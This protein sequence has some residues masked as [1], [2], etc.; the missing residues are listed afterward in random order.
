DQGPR[1]RGGAPLGT[2]G[3]R[4][5]TAAAVAV[6]SQRQ[7]D[8]GGIGLWSRTDW[9]SPWLT[10]WAGRTL[11]AARGAGVPVSDTVL[12]RLADYLSTQL[13]NP[14]RL[15]IP[16]AYFWENRKAWLAEQTAAVDFLSPYGRPSVPIENSLLQTGL[17]LSWEDRALL[18]EILARRRLL[19]PAR[20]ILADVLR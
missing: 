10:A 1:E 4:R 15:Y 3:P 14:R 7:R 5:E 13:H 9:T 11:L 2:G 12:G 20:R 16:V 17:G 18:A 19:E 8:D 6:L